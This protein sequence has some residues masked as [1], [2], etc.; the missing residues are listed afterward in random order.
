MNINNKQYKIIYWATLAGIVL[1]GVVLDL[2]EV[3]DGIFEACVM[4][5][6]YVQYGMIVASLLTVYL[7][8]KLIKKNPI[9]RMT[10]I[11]APLLSN[12]FFYHSFMNTSFL[13]LA[14]ISLIAYVFVYPA[15]TMENDNS[16]L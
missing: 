11:E 3:V 7:A 1:F 16:K 4:M 13:Y 15:K 9:L 8:L 14:I 5:E 12:I 2:V 6:F 10:L